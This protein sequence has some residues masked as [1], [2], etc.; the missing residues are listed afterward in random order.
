M[1]FRLLTFFLLIACFGSGCAWGLTLGFVPRANAVLVNDQQVR[2]LQEYL[3]ARLEEP[4]D[5][6]IFADGEK[7]REWISRHRQIDLAVFPEAVFSASP[8]GEVLPLC[9]LRRL[10]DEGSGEVDHLV[11]RQGLGAESLERLRLLPGVL[12]VDESGLA[13]RSD[14]PAAPAEAT[15]A[16]ETQ[17]GAGPEPTPEVSG[18]PAPT[19]PPQSSIPALPGEGLKDLGEF[20]PVS[21]EADQLDFDQANNLYRAAGQVRLRKGGVTLTSDSVT[22][23]DAS[24][25]ATAEGNVLI[26]EP[27]GTMEGERVAINLG[28]DRGR[29]INGRIL[30]R[31]NNFH[32][33][34]AE[35]EKLGE[36]TYQVKDG[37]FTT[38]DGETPSWKFGAGRL[39]VTLGEYAKARHVVFYLHELPVFY[40]PYLIYPVKTERESGL[41]MP[42]YGY[43]DNR[44]L[45]LSLAYYQVIDRNM[46]ATFYL[47]YLSELGVGTGLEYRYI[48]GEDTAG[49]A[50]A[51]HVAGTSGEDDRYAL[52]WNHSGLLPGRVRMAADVEYVSSRDYFEDF[53]EVSGEYNKDKAQS[54]LYLSRNWDKS[55]LGGQLKYT[56]DLEG[57]NDL[58]LQRLPEVR[59][60]L[61]RQRIADSPLFYEV[62]NSYTYFWRQGGVKGQ[63]LSVRPALAAV[64]QPGGMLGI[65]PEIG[66]RQ[67]FYTT[68]HDGPGEEQEGI[69]DFTTR[70]STQLERIYNRPGKRI[71]KIR[72]SLVPE[73]V[74]SY[75]P[76][77]DQSHLP[78]FDAEDGI[79][80]DN[81]I[82][83]A[84]TNRFTARLE[85][86]NGEFAYHEFL[87]LRLS[88]E[89]DI[90]ES[91]RDV[92]DPS[93]QRRPFSDLRTEL[94]LRPTRWS[95]LDLDSSYDIFYARDG[96][97]AFNLGGGIQDGAGNGLSLDYRYARDAQEYFAGA[98][99]TSWLKPVYLNYQHRYDFTDS[100]TLEQVLNLEYRAQC[101]S[102][103]LTLRDRLDDQEYL[104]SFALSGLGRVAKLGGSLGTTAD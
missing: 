79:G 16:V 90:G 100:K 75:I 41:L 10:A 55:H 89:Y 92:L 35:I 65:E 57:D 91:R 37:S 98:V 26:T 80:P 6:Q 58:T 43:S 101:W 1:L 12:G 38:C 40:L 83:Y 69:F 61:L 84:L 21:L 85:P 62:E 103:F 27:S 97:S 32:I 29:V 68:S 104:V 87:Y 88:Q 63:R 15:P 20:S 74:Y 54:V 7:L 72:H 93:D 67:R 33:A 52:N 5:L 53:G 102:L 42:R 76:D 78:Q 64:F 8:A 96:F 95:Y 60:N 25:V 70:I 18:Q 86:E 11:A 81:S 39:D 99:D 44:G 24:G 45:Q 47:D 13:G 73:V 3:E 2:S 34:G 50:T 49:E 17:P 94:I 51:Y 9:Q 48:F 23:D 14:A 59:F 31:E 19:A 71:E 56:K 82:E 4:V 22:W 46:D 77:E 66:Y 30:L 28:E 36:Q